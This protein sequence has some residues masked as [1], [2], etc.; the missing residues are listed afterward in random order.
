MK[1]SRHFLKVA[2]A[3][4][5]PLL[6]ASV[7]SRGADKSDE[8]VRP[9]TEGRYRLVVT[10]TSADRNE[11]IAG[12]TVSSVY[13]YG[14]NPS[15]VA[16]E[17]KEK[18]GDDGKV[19]LVYDFTGNKWQPYHRLDVT[20]SHPD[21]V[22]T[23]RNV[24]I[25]KNRPSG[26]IAIPVS[27]KRKSSVKVVT[28]SVRAADDGSP[29]IDAHVALRGKRKVAAIY[30]ASTDREG[31]AVIN[32]TEGDDYEV[33]VTH[34]GFY[35]VETSLTVKGYD[36][37]QKSYNLNIQM[38]RM[39]SRESPTP[40]PT[41]TPES[42]SP[43]PTPP[44][45]P[46]PSP[47]ADDEVT[48]PDL[49]VFQSITEMKTV[50][51]HA[52]LKAQLISAKENPPSKE[53]E[54]KVAGQSPA[55]NTK[56]KKGSTVTVSIYQ[57]FE[58][59]SPTTPAVTENDPFVGKWSGT[60]VMSDGTKE[61]KAYEIQ[62]KGDGYVMVVPKA[63]PIPLKLEGGKL[64]W[65]TTFTISADV[66]I[67]MG[68]AKGTGKGEPVKISVTMTITPAG[69]G[70]SVNIESKR[71]KTGKIESSGKGMFSRQ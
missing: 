70:L 8:A 69:S 3:T 51:A 15:E 53:K 12:A 29:I 49:S 5:L 9:Q 40:T 48:V 20:I 33:T 39:G 32:V 7:M 14:S 42:P 13:H 44:P 17:Q 21:F 52:E 18:T 56:V 59:T 38:R 43:T 66:S 27:L 67:S 16:L 58:D 37:E 26:D 71:E 57:K 24:P 63:D 25:T 23:Y 65:Q 22:E 30:D 45:S 50:L 64:I 62:K 35:D 4:S 47:S 10:V 36:D 34:S 60:M 11:A 1:V 6:F 55:P 19:Y 2:V 31:M 41:P 28:A 54:F 61:T 46:S 68:K